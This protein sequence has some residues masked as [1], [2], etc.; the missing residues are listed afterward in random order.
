MPTRPD[1]K[2]LSDKSIA[3]CQALL[4][5][6]GQQFI[7]GE[8]SLGDLEAE[9]KD[10]LKAEYIRQY[11]F[12]VGG[13]ANMTA[14]DWQ[15]VA[16]DLEKQYR[17]ADNFLAQLE[18]ADALQLEDGGEALAALFWRFGLY[19][20]AAG[21]IYEYA[22]KLAAE[23]EEKDEERWMLDEALARDRHCEGCLGYADLDWV[24]IGTLPEP[25]DGSTPCEVN[26][27]CWKEYRNSG[28]ES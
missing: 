3:A 2:I 26:C 6:L 14:E 16:T 11:L 7:D 22:N 25:G 27:H 9:L 18:E 17:Y 23:R 21:A 1:K 8:I 10:E 19:A 15:Q 5:E 13:E 20:V 24:P 12:G 4:E 28:K